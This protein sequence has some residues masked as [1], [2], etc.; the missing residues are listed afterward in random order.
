MVTGTINNPGTVLME[1]ADMDHL[2]L[3]ARVD[4]ES[5]GQVQVG[6]QAIVHLKG[7]GSERFSGP[8]SGLL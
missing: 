6:Q 8:S 3:V 4:E 1:V 5:I 7:Y 2:L